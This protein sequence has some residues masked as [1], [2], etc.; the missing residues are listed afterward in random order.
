MRKSLIV[1]I[2]HYDHIVDL[3]GAVHDALSVKAVLE[4]NANGT[5]NFPTP[6]VMLGTGPVA[7]VTRRQLK[8]AVRQLFS[9]DA[10]IALFYFAGHGYIEDTGGFL[11]AS[12]STSGDDGLALSDVMSLANGSQARNKVII[13]DSCYSGVAA[14]NAHT[15]SISEVSNGMT[16]LTA[17]TDKQE[18]M[19]SP[20]G[21][22]GI[23][24]ALLI[25][26][27][28]GAAANLR[29]AITPGSVYA[30]IDQSLGPWSQRPVFK[31][32]VTSFIS[33]R[34]ARPPI[35]L[36]DLQ[37]ITQLFPTKTS[38]YELDP[39]YEPHRSGVE[40]ESVPAP[41]PKHTEAFAVLQNYVKVN[42]ARPV[43]APHMW[44]AAMNSAA[45]ELTLLGRHYWNLV[46]K[47]LI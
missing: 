45:C 36:G 1:G 13:L 16:I 4:R 7:R 38:V 43:G 31:T 30:H 5:L 46:H 11:C 14:S 41:D 28:N 12:D 40:D 15:S 20:G 21:G 33:L 22:S 9:G 18:A 39:S 37:R 24:T 26:A 42:L 47:G 10:E 44:H 25:D 27:L 34:E 3:S 23:F 2:D 17:S 8:D 32:N 6:H 19:E 35:D 29:G